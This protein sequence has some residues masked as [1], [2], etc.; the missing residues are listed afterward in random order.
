M[1][2]HFKIINTTTSEIVEDS[3]T[4]LDEG[5]P[6]TGWSKYESAEIVGYKV[7][8]VDF[9][10]RQQYTVEVYPV[11]E[12]GDD[13][14]LDKNYGRQY[15]PE[16]RDDPNYWGDAIQDE[17]GGTKCYNCENQAIT[18]SWIEGKHVPI[19]EECIPY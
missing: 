6:F 15:N 5:V 8:D 1:K 10:D 19:C 3:A 9:K 13:E 17:I 18:Y 14:R 4:P 11:P 2:Y 16:Q 7:L 12:A